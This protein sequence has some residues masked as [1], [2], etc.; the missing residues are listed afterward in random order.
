MAYTKFKKIPGSLIS[1]DFEKAFDTVDTSFLLLV[2]RKFNFGDSFL[3]WISILYN[4]AESC[5]INNGVSTGYF[6]V[7]RG[8]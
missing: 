1:I 5:V 8:V 4:K 7:K 3:K 2:L 6:D